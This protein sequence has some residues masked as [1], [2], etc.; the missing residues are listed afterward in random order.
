[1]RASSVQAEAALIKTAPQALLRQYSSE[2]E[3]YLQW[4]SRF[5]IVLLTS[6]DITLGGVL[7]GVSA[8]GRPFEQYGS[9]FGAG[10]DIW[11]A[12]NVC[13]YVRHRRFAFEDRSFSSDAYSGNETTL[14]L[15][16][17]F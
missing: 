1:M 3:L 10:C 17:L 2:N 7:T 14:E 15:K 6:G 5:A 11:A 13:V 16:L 12:D 4:N 8:L 9:A